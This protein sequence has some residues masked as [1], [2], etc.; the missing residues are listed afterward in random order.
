MLRILVFEEPFSVKLRLEGKL[1]SQ[2]VPVL[3]QRWADVR[4][5]LKG[6]KA[7]LDLG[8]VRE[9]DEAGRSTL[10]WLAGSGARL[11]YA[12]AKMRPVVDAIAREVRAATGLTALVKR[13][14]ASVTAAMSAA[15]ES[16]WFARLCAVLPASVRPCGCGPA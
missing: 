10:R 9:L 13:W 8:D 14:R 2:T 11:G 16:E 5:G 6:R 12:N 15:R 3:A 4:S 1:T 7:I